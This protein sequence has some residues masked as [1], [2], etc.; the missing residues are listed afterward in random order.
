MKTTT[1]EGYTIDALVADLRLVCAAGREEREVLSAVRPL[2]LRMAASK[3]L[4]LEERMCRPDPEQGFGIHVLHEEPD[5]TLA[6]FVVSWAPGRGTPAH[7]HGTWAVV[8]GI[9]GP[10]KNEFWRRADD[11][12]RPGY[13][14]VEKH[15]EKVF[16]PGDVL[17]LPTGAIHSV[18]N[19][20]DRITVSLHI[21]GRH[22]NFTARS[23]YDPERRT[24]TLY[25]VKTNA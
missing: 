3:D 20:T 15:A 18:R 2:A 1:R 22:V 19:E 23:Q 24:E 9:D 6:V 12:G 5:H 25:K 17:A 11:G 8:V 7:D 14:E 13:A 21:Y 16:G 4:W 10:E